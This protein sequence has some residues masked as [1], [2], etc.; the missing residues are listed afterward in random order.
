M[1]NWNWTPRAQ[2]MGYAIGIAT[3]FVGL[4]LTERL[5]DWWL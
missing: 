1:R 4:E 3:F 5:L 2:R